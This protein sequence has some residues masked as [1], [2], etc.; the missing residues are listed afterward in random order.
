MIGL[1]FPVKPEWI[2]AVHQLW[3]PNQLI[4]D[5]MA[6]GKSNAMPEI[7]GEEAR[8]KRLT[9]ILRYFVDTE[10]NGNARVTLPDDVWVMYSRAYPST[11]MAPAYLAHLIAQNDVVSELTQYLRKR[12]APGDDVSS[13][14]VRQHAS[15]QFGE[16]RV[17]TNTASAFLRTLQH[18]GVLTDAK[19]VGQYQYAGPLPTSCEVFPLLVWSWWQVHLAPQILLETFAADPAFTFLE[20]DNFSTCWEVYHSELWSIEAR[21]EGQRAVLRH[22]DAPGF[23][24]ALMGGAK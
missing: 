24:A 20:T 13:S 15:A 8:R 5:L 22:A 19:G 11:V 18:F 2:H 3:Q 23:A 7:A 14:M 21:I 10:G 9:I 12:I 6:L 4:V 1:D 17:V 16:R